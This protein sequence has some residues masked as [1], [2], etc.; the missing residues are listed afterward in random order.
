M[1]FPYFLYQ[2]VNTEQNSEVGMS[3]FALKQ[4]S[5]NR[6]MDI[7]NWAFH[8]FTGGVY[9]TDK[10]PYILAYSS[11]SWIPLPYGP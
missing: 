5:N 3:T 4:K 10:M 7:D 2:N 11:P 9:T 1:P 8:T 6:R